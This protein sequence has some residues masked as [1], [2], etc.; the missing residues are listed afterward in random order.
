MRSKDIYKKC[1]EAL[2]LGLRVTLTE[3]DFNG[4]VRE[5]P[6]ETMSDVCD[7]L[8]KMETHGGDASWRIF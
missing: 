4:E 1:E 8:R 5:F 7:Y 6:A 2:K 3:Q